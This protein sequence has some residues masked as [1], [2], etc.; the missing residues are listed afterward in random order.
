[1]EGRPA[2]YQLDRIEVL[3]RELGDVDKTI[4]GL[5]TKDAR[6]LDDELRQRKLEPL[7]Q[8][9]AL[10]RDRDELDDVALHCVAS[11]GR[12]CGADEAVAT[13][14]ERD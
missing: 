4:T 3:R 13:R 10:E 5:L 9:S 12:E 14:N 6:A 8:L 11:G 1:W 2:R 7:P